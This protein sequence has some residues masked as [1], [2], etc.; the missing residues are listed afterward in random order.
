MRNDTITIG[1]R[2]TGIE[3]V[4]RAER[5]SLRVVEGGSA[6][7][8]AR[9]GVP[10]RLVPARETPSVL[11]GDAD[12]GV[13]SLLSFA[14]AGEFDLW[15]ARDGEEALRMALIEQPDLI[16]LDARLPKI[17]GFR[18]TRQIRRNPATSET[19]VIMLD[20][21]PERIDIMRGFAAGA[22]DYFTKPFDPTKLL[23]RMREALDSSDLAC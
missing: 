16:L 7:A 13:L 1:Y 9:T 10:L 5:A 23:A 3:P 19:P 18:V 6:A 4:D 20:T 21:D 2:R 15:R 11:I 8:T 17:D 14:L 12:E 22:N